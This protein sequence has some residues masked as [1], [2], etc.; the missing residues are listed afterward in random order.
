MLLI[1]GLSIIVGLI[2]VWVT[3]LSAIRTFVLPRPSQDKIVNFVFISIRKLF[4]IRLKRLKTYAA[5]DW[6]MAMYAPFGLIAILPVWYTLMLLGYGLVFWGLG[7]FSWYQAFRM[8]GSSLLTLGFE[9]VNSPIYSILAFSEAVLG[10]LLVALLIAYLPTIYAAFSR[11]ESAVKL[12]EVRAGNPPSAVEMLKRYYRIQGIDR[13]VDEWTSWERWFADIDESHTSLPFLVYFRSPQADHS[14]ITAAGAVLDGASLYL[15]AT[16]LPY[17][18]QG[19]LCIRAGYLALR[20]IADLFDIEYPTQ[21]GQGDPISVSRQQFE[22][23]IEDL[24]NAG[25]PIASNHD[26][27][28]LDFTGW[29]VNYDLPL[30]KIAEMVIAP[31]APWINE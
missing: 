4:G 2:L 25:I 13:L 30:L 19:A 27:A 31:R 14:W 20:H 6:L 3:V 24:A 11:R 10:L 17:N 15:S 28:W 8:S 22:D 5:R 26:Q 23:A 21:V 9:P 7:E 18:A 29:R 1:K 12:L 16:E